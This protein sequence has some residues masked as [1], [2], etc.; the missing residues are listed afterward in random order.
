V[1]A[2]DHHKNGYKLCCRIASCIGRYSPVPYVAPELPGYT[3]VQRSHYRRDGRAALGRSD[4]LPRH[5]A[6]AHALEPVADHAVDLYFDITDTANFLNKDPATLLITA[7][8]NRQYQIGPEEEFRFYPLKEAA[9]LYLYQRDGVFRGSAMGMA[10]ATRLATT[11][12]PGASGAWATRSTSTAASN[13]TISPA[14][15]SRPAERAAPRFRG[16]FQGCI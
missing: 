3:F 14:C 9:T 6:V 7:Y 10:R 4:T 15:R 2:Q 5:L 1:T 12:P 8:N 11:S 16:S 13:M